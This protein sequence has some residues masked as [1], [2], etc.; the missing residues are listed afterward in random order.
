MGIATIFNDQ[1]NTLQNSRGNGKI[2]VNQQVLCQN[3]DDNN[4]NGN[5]EDYDEEFFKNYFPPFGWQKMQN[6]QE[7][8]ADVKLATNPP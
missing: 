5:N 7:Q 3:S 8:E 2:K 4:D 1:Q 6:R